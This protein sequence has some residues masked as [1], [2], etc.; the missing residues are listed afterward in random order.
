MTLAIERG[1]HR[2]DEVGELPLQFLKSSDQS[3]RAAVA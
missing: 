3:G 1:G 2:H